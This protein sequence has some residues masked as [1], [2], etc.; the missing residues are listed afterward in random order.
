MTYRIVQQWY[1]AML[2]NDRLLK[3]EKST[4]W[5]SEFKRRLERLCFSIIKY[6]SLFSEVV[7]RRCRMVRLV[8]DEL[9]V[10]ILLVCF[11]KEM[12][13]K[14]E[15]KCERMVVC[16]TREEE[17]SQ[18]YWVLTQHLCFIFIN[19]CLQQC[20]CNRIVK[21]NHWLCHSV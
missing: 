6:W 7:T 8:R 9:C 21:A 18:G 19:P 20:F 12:R 15:F 16:E 1:C 17:T 4:G 5:F 14:G 13:L 3:I 2:K 11:L 10:C